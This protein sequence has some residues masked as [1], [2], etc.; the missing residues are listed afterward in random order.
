MPCAQNSVKFGLVDEAQQRKQ[1]GIKAPTI[2]ITRKVRRC[3]IRSIACLR[4]A[5]AAARSAL[6]TRSGS[7][8]FVSASACARPPCARCRMLQALTDASVSIVTLWRLCRIGPGRCLYPMKARMA[9]TP[10]RGSLRLIFGFSRRAV[11]NGRLRGRRYGRDGGRD[12]DCGWRSAPRGRYG[13][14]G[15]SAC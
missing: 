13:G 1:R 14:R 4:S 6:V 9:F 12:R 2:P 3:S 15:R 10:P 7:T 5:L 8:C 11:S